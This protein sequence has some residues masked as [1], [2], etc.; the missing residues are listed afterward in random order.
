MCFAHPRV[1]IILRTSTF[2]TQDAY[3]EANKTP[4]QFTEALLN[5]TIFNFKYKKDDPLI[6][7]IANTLWQAS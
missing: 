2:F 6:P 4:Q 3:C 5:L 1:S 7:E